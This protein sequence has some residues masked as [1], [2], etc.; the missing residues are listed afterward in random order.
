MVHDTAP[1]RFVLVPKVSHPWYD[2]VHRGAREQAQFL[3]RQTGRR[4]VVDQEPPAVA[5]VAEQ[6]ALLDRVIAAAPT[7][8]ALDPVDTL[9]HLPALAAARQRGIPVLVF[10]APSSNPDEIGRA[11]V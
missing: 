11:H 3:A 4:I 8:I 9:A 7:G 2:E 1:L 5:G 10:D 6:N